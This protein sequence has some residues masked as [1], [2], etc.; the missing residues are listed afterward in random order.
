MG[1]LICEK[2]I[3]PFA[4]WSEAELRRAMKDGEAEFLTECDLL[5]QREEL[6]RKIGRETH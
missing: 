1:V 4:A 3:K 5:D 2:R 6:H